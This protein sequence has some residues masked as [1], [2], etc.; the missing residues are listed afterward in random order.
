M[1]VFF[2]EASGTAFAT[3]IASPVPLKDLDTHLLEVFCSNISICANNIAL[4]N[5]LKEQA[6]ID[7]GLQIPNLPALVEKMKTI[8][9]QEGERPLTLCILDIDGFNQINEILGH[10]YGDEILRALVAR[11]R[12]FL[13]PETF[14]ARVASDVFA[15][16]AVSSLEEDHEKFAARIAAGIKKTE[17]EKI[18]SDTREGLVIAQRNLQKAGELINS[19]KHVAS[20]QTS[21]IRRRFTLDETL[22]EVLLTIQPMLKRTR[23]ALQTDISPSIELDSF[24][25]VLGQII[26][27]LITNAL[28][29]AWDEGDQGTISI[30]AHPYKAG[31]RIN[32][33]DNGKGMD[34]EVARHIMEPFYTT[35][36]G[37]GG[38]GLGLHI[39][40]NAAVHILGGELTFTTAVQ[41]GTTFFLDIPLAAPILDPAQ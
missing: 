31:V 14:A 36:M 32:V 1:T 26:T 33:S 39:A 35:K 4:V 21:S 3:W 5:R 34:E 22:R 24:P 25:G 28:A 19:F 16:M 29:H 18:L 17:L 37:S 12:E 7:P 30:S 9:A 13:P 41:I 10:E 11:L 20:D 27:N 23:H 15:L 40:H 2:G 6:W 8:L 38:T